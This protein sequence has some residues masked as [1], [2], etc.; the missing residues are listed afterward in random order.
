MDTIQLQVL[1]V[2][3]EAYPESMRMRV[4]LGKLPALP[5]AQTRRATAY[6]VEKGYA[7]ETKVEVGLI[8]LLRDREAGTSYKI[9]AKGIDFLEG[10]QEEAQQA[11]SE[12]SEG[13]LEALGNSIIISPVFQGRNFEPEEALCFVLMPLREPFISIFEN[14]VKP[15]VL[16]LGLN[17]R[18]AD[19]I[20]SNRPVIEDVWASINRA[21]LIIADLTG[22]NPNV[23]YELGIAHTLGKEV[24]MITQQMEDVPFDV[25]HFRV[26][27]YKYPSGIEE[28]EKKLSET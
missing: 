28:F 26:I 18:K 5:E 12:K 6:L 11:G 10:R 25:F 20:S 17:A 15:T 4:V 14:N 24:V 2:L 16:K 19:D 23:F 27:H 13:S 9:T 22:R 7:D 3:N 21:R 1:K 8:P